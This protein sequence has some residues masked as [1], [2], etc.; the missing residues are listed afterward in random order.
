MKG[1]PHCVRFEPEWEKLKTKQNVT[2]KV[3]LITYDSNDDE[4]IVIAYR[5]N[6]FPTILYQSS[7]GKIIPYNGQ[8]E[9]KAIEDFI[10][11]L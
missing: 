8:R 3:N 7:T 11:N 5:I 2:N 6:G 9:C 4:K 1:C 10:N